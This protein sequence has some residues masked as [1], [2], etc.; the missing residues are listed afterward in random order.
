MGTAGS[1]HLRAYADNHLLVAT[2]ER[3]PYSPDLPADRSSAFVADLIDA[4][5]R[6]TDLFIPTHSVF[7]TAQP[8]CWPKSPPGKGARSS[9]IPPLRYE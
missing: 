2:N 5:E 4:I 6:G 8:A 9:R 7:A 3:A 1:A